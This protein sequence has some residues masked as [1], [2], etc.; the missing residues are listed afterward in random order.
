MIVSL[1]SHLVTDIVKHYSGQSVVARN[2]GLR[3]GKSAVDERMFNLE[4]KI[5]QEGQAHWEW[6][7]E[8]RFMSWYQCC[9]NK[10]VPS[11]RGGGLDSRPPA[12]AWV[13]GSGGPAGG[14]IKFIALGRLAH[15]G[16]WDC[17]P[18]AGG[19]GSTVQRE[20]RP[21]GPPISP[22]EEGRF[23]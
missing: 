10:N 4:I 17:L 22:G 9:R 11:R 15:G 20:S 8:R 13:W 21:R 14:L 2:S 23:G 18:R 6:M 12:W 3:M 5:P 1:K 19:P 16:N 7:T